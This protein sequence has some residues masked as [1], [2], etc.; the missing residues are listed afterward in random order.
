MACLRLPSSAAGAIA[1]ASPGEREHNQTDAR[2]TTSRPSPL[3]YRKPEV[4]GTI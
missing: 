1:G 3:R 2:S 4:G